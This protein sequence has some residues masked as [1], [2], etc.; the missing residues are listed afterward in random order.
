MIVSPPSLNLAS[1]RSPRSASMYNLQSPRKSVG[2]KT[3]TDKEDTLSM[4]TPTSARRPQN[5]SID[6]DESKRKYNESRM[7]SKLCPN[8]P[9]FDKGTPRGV[10]YGFLQ[11]H[12][13]TPRN[14]CFMC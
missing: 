4:K 6:L 7:W 1:T 2:P 10:Y 13:G 5:L 3:P 12:R 11:T 9:S 8:T 14:V